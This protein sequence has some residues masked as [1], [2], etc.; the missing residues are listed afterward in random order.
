MLEMLRYAPLLA[1]FLEPMEMAIGPAYDGLER[2]VKTT[3]A[4][5]AGDLDQPPNRRKNLLEG[6]PQFVNPGIGFR[7]GCHLHHWSSG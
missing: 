1:I 5:G 3:Q 7:L 6:D 4:E 2:I